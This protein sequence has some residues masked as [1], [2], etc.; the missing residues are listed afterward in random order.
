MTKGQVKFDSETL[1]QV[2]QMAAPPPPKKKRFR[3]GRLALAATWA[4]EEGRI[5]C[6]GWIWFL[7]KA[8]NSFLFVVFVGR[9]PALVCHCD[10][11]NGSCSVCSESSKYHC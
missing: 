2:P 1:G 9:G 11:V 8:Q 10:S 5:G 7:G 6:F 4:L 3:R